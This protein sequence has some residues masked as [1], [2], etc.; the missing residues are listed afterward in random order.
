MNDFDRFRVARYAVLDLCPERAHVAIGER[1]QG[2]YAAVR[3][4]NAIVISKSLAV[5][6]PSHGRLRIADGDRLDGEFSTARDDNSFLA[7]ESDD[8]TCR[9]GGKRIGWLAD[10]S[11]GS[12]S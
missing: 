3:D 7:H 8:A 4:G 2:Q 5:A 10:D 9:L 12:S 1:S 6:I 11:S